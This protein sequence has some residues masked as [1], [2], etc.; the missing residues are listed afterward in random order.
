MKD[1][2]NLHFSGAV[3]RKMELQISRCDY[4]KVSP[5]CVLWEASKAGW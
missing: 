1:W 2:P 3:S 5:A 4:T